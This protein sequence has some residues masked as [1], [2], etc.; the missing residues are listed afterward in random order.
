MKAAAMNGCQGTPWSEQLKGKDA[1]ERL[2]DKYD[3]ESRGSAFF[4]HNSS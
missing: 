3:R 4:L 2:G 1:I